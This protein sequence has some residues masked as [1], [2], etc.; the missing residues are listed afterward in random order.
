MHE[1][2]GNR[3]FKMPAQRGKREREVEDGEWIE[4]K[5]ERGRKSGER[6]ARKVGDKW[7]TFCLPA[8][9]FSSA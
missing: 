9:Q 6:R 4:R 8:V 7:K 3:A 2:Q 1:L 5:R